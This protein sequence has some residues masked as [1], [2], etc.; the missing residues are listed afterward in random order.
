MKS[1]P[2]ADPILMKCEHMSCSYGGAP[3]IE[4]VDISINRGEFIGIVG[5]SGSGKTTLLR[6]LLGSIKPVHGKVER[7]PG[8]RLAY[9]P[10]LETVDWNFPVTVGEVVGTTHPHHF[11]HGHWEIPIDCF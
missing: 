3:V 1:S 2:G 10:Q 11:A 7:L 8:L 4:N 9:V 5:P 6:A